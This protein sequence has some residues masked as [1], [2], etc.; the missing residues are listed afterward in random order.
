MYAKPQFAP[1][2]M[3]AEGATCCHVYVSGETLNAI[4]TNPACAPIGQ[5]PTCGPIV[6]STL[7]TVSVNVL[8]TTVTVTGN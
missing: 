3:D 4:V 7:C 1:I 6:T 5:F 8:G 2:A